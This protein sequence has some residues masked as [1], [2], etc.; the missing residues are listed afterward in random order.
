MKILLKSVAIVII[1]FAGLIALPT[2]SAQIVSPPLQSE[3]LYVAPNQTLS[4][5]INYS[6]SAPESTQ[7]VGLA[8]RVHFD[9]SKLSFADVNS[10]LQAGI[11]PVGEVQNDTNNADNDANTDKFFVLAWVDVSGGWPGDANALPLS[12]FTSQFIANEDF[13]GSTKVAF[14]A[15]SS[16][17]DA[18]FNATVQT[19][20]RKPEVSLSS[21]DINII[22]GQQAGLNV[23]LDQALPEECGVLAVNLNASGTAT[24]GSDYQAF[25]TEILFLPNEA[26]VP[27][28]I[29]TLD[30]SSIEAEKSLIISIVEGG[31]YSLS[32]NQAAELNFTLT[33]NDVSL[34]LSINPNSVIETAENK[35]STVTLTRS[36]YLDAALDVSYQI[37]GTATQGQ[38]FSSNNSTSLF[39]FDAGQ[40]TATVNL[41]VV[42]DAVNE[43]DETVIITLQEGENYSL[44]Q[45]ASVTLMIKDAAENCIDIDG[46]GKLDALTDGILLARYLLG[47]RDASLIDNS[48]ANDAVR[49]TATVVQSYIQSYTATGCYDVDG[50]GNLDALSDA[51]LLIRYLSGYRGGGLIEGAIGQGATRT[52]ADS[53]SAYI[54]TLVT[55]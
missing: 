48:L 6:I 29:T 34:G 4:M 2:Y 27:L 7:E 20:C 16:S 17:G 40:N 8:L 31:N 51:T 36:G 15:S 42:N 45:E 13:S 22:E 23:L 38:D 49:T 25:S 55:Q 1:G 39:H 18:P 46:N 43:G 3:I 28:A 50:S 21:N 37:S 5:P 35:I 44:P 24:A 10:L 32:S 14:T 52:T 41:T 30:D 54:E 12:L 33:S 26:S 9:S 19:I 53:V 11:Q 47:Y